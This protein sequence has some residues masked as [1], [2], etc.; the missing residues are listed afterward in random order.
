MKDSINDLVSISR[1]FGADPKWVVAGGGN[2][3]LK[4]DNVLYVKASGFPLA[5]IDEGGFAKMDRDKLE[6]IWGSDYPEG[7]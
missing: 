4:V 3:S 2:T 1:E 5:T 7:G 6:A